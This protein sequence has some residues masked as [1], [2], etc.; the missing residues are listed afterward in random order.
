MNDGI[1]AMRLDDGTHQRLI[2]DVADDRQYWLGQRGAKSGGEVVEHDDAF[3]GVDQLMDRVT[4]DITRAAGHQYG[5][6]RFLP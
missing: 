6:G 1:D 5:H 2:A 4:A 3:A